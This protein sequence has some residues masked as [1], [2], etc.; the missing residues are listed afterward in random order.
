[1]MEFLYLISQEINKQKATELYQ[2][3][4]VNITDIKEIDAFNAN[5]Q[6]Q[7]KRPN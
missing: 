1:M 4:I 2:N 7:I 3:G 5:Q 6:I